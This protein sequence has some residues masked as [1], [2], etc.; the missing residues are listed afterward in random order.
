[1]FWRLRDLAR[2]RR[3]GHR[4]RR[5]RASLRGDQRSRSTAK[6]H[7]PT[8]EVYGIQPAPVLRLVTCGGVFDRRPPGH[9]RDN[10]VVYADEIAGLARNRC[11][12]L[13]L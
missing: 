7:F 5:R 11:R 12:S 9:Y 1:V 6:D 10:V 13:M 8:H 3:R 4:H 2:R